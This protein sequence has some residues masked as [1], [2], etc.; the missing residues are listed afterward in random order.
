[1]SLTKRGESDGL[2]RKGGEPKKRASKKVDKPVQCLKDTVKGKNFGK[3]VKK[4]GNRKKVR[5]G[6]EEKKLSTGVCKC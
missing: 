6:G 2:L 1:M 4:P 5:Y 3:F